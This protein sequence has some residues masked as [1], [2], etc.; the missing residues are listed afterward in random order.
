MIVDY[1]PGNGANPEEKRAAL[2]MAD[3]FIEQMKYPRMKTQVGVVVG[4]SLLLAHFNICI[5]TPLLSVC[6]CTF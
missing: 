3:N 2:Q 6:I 4:G 5:L 1:P